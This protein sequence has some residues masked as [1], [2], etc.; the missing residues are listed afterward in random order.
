M[1]REK[2]IKWCKERA[3][4]EYDYYAKKDPSSAVRNGITSIM[5]DIR[6]HPETNS[7]SLVMLCTMQLMRKPNMTRQEF[8]NFI[9]GF[10]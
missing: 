7:E 2:H 8:V 1:T 3:I 6:K 4:F 9:N 5:S 10:H